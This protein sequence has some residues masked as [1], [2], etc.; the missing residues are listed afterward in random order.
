MLETL[1]QNTALPNLHP[2][3]V[4]FPIAALPLA[5]GFEFMGLLL[6]RRQW[7]AH[8]ATT[9]YVVAAG[10][11]WLAVLAGERAADGLSSVPA[12][13]QPQIGEHSDWGHYSLYALLALAALRLVLHRS[14][15]TTDHRGVRCLVLA[16]GAVSAGALF[17]TADLGGGLVYEHGLAVQLEEGASS[18]SVASGAANSQLDTHGSEAEAGSAHDRLVEK[19]DGSLVWTPSHSDRDALGDLLT[20]VPRG[21]LDVVTWV[22]SVGDPS[23]GLTLDVDGRATLVLPGTYSDVQVEAKLELV[24]WQ[25]TIGVVHHVDRQASSEPDGGAFTLSDD[26]AASLIDVRD[27]QREVLDE[28]NALAPRGTFT[29]AVSAAGKHLKGLVD[30]ETVTHGHIAAGAPGACGIVLDGSGRI[31]ILQLNV[32]SLEG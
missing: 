31:R 22:E 6:I 25:G 30:G 27:G 7:L 20:A 10:S 14:K 24:D 32:I 11:A 16:L 23:K 26:G 21:G 29:L 13:V 4:H 8:A 19:D 15:K 3:L 5:L 2:A 9:L 12:K 18:H 1:V 17:W 28:G